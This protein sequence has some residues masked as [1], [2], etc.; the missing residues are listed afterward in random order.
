MLCLEDAE[1]KKKSKYRICSENYSLL[2]V[3]QVLGTVVGT[4]PILTHIY[5]Y[6]LLKKILGD[7]HHYCL[8][9]MEQEIAA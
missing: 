7:G 1:E 8:H 2:I 5:L 3:Y 6:L 4:I 9:F